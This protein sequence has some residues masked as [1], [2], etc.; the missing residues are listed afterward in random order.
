MG[1]LASLQYGFLRCGR[2]SFFERWYHF[3]LRSFLIGDEGRFCPQLLQLIDNGNANALRHIS[4]QDNRRIQDQ[5]GDI[6][7]EDVLRP[8]GEEGDELRFIGF[9]GNGF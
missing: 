4:T 9:H 1:G 2:G 7:G 6:L 5:I 3:W 8:F